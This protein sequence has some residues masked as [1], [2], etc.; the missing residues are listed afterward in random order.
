MRLRFQNELV[1]IDVLSILLVIIISFTDFSVLRIILGLP[2]VLF[3]PGYVLIAVLFPRAT[4]IGGFERVALSFGFS[5]AVAGLVGLVLNYT[6]WGVSL[7]PVL[8]SLTVFIVAMS[9]IAWFRRRGLP[10]SERYAVNFIFD[11]SSWK[12]QTFANRVLSIVLVAVIAGAVGTLGYAIASP[13]IG[14]RYTEFYILGLEGKAVDY[15][16]MLEVGQQ[17]IVVAGIINR[18]HEVARY[19][20]EVRIG[21]AVNNVLQQVVLEHDEKW[22]DTIV[23]IPEKAGNSQKVEFLLYNLNN[24]DSEVYRQLHFWVDVADRR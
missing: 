19:R 10:Q 4:N 14:E 24:S 8:L 12:T 23:F 16:R 2:F 18:E 5:V 1:L 6:P 7:Y 13:K 17:G 22:E 21:E 20:L 11:L 3:F 15:P 9:V